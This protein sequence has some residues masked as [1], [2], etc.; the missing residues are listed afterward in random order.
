[1][2]LSTLPYCTIA[3]A[4]SVGTSLYVNIEKVDVGCNLL[5]A[6][7]KKIAIICTY[8]FTHYVNLILQS[9]IYSCRIQQ[10]S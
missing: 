10:Q 8:W 3:R 7:L 2:Y 5:I 1:M 4:N 9:I 6:I